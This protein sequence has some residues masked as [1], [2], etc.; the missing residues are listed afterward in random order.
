MQC[1]LS[2]ILDP[3]LH[4]LHF[5][6]SFA[7]WRISQIRE[8]SAYVAFAAKHE[9]PGYEKRAKFASLLDGFLPKLL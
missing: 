6:C 7:F 2:Y 4:N 8:Q 1:S 3:H 5:Y 9:N